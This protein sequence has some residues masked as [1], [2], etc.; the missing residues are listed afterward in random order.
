MGAA[1]KVALER[2]PRAV[3]VAAFLHNVVMGAPGCSYENWMVLAPITP[4]YV[5]KLGRKNY[6]HKLRSVRVFAAK[7]VT[8]IFL[9]AVG[10][11]GDWNVKFYVYH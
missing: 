4:H 8:V 6:R 9:G 5:T 11:S 7:T 1:Q 2:N 3:A 10:R